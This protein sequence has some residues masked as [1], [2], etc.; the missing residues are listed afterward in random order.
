[1]KHRHVYSTQEMAHARKAIAALHM[2]GIGNDAISLVARSDVE[3]DRIPDTLKEADT[4]SVPAAVRGMELGGAT[5]LLAGLA[6]VAF[7]PFGVTLA[8]AVAIG[9]M[10][11]LVGGWSSALMGA[12]LPDP[13]RQQF[14]DEIQ[15]GRVLVL[16]DIEDEQ[17]PALREAMAEA[18]AA[19]LDYVSPVGAK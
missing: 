8:G 6:A 4:D 5:G 11:A 12:A 1:M 14:D 10:G 15:A 16:A 13:V 18:G 19:D 7:A 9:A 3:M 17:L 2:R